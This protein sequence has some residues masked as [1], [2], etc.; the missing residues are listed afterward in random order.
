MKVSI[1]TVCHNAEATI[2]RCIESV[3]RQNYPVEHILIDGN[4][5]DST[6]EIAKD[7]K[8]INRIISEPDK[9]IYDA[10]NKGLKLADGEIIG[11]LNADDLLADQNC[12]SSLISVFSQNK[13]EAVF[14]NI[15][16]FDSTPEKSCLRKYAT[17]G[18]KPWWLKFGIMPPHLGTYL[19]RSVFQKYGN[20]R[21]GYTIAADYEFFVRIFYKNNIKYSY[22]NETI[23]KMQAGGISNKDLYH[24]WLLNHEIIKACMVNKLYTNWFYLLLK[25][26]YRLAELKFA[27]IR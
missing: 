3:S 20:F 16:F 7:C 9:G 27:K 26:P 18:F 4:S 8:S 17:P 10:M 13:V 24:R 1:I 11:F 25:I 12:I 22:M 19:K 5:T 23:V 6:I 14:G 15:E 2:K 21:L